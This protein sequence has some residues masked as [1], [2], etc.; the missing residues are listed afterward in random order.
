[1]SANEARPLSRGRA[2]AAALLLSSV[3]S[4]PGPAAANARAPT[5]PVEAALARKE[6]RVG[7]QAFHR[8]DWPVALQHLRKA[9]TLGD[10]N[11]LVALGDGYAFDEFGNTHTEPLA[12]VLYRAAAERANPAGME[13]LG[14]SYLA[15]WYGVHQDYTRARKWLGRAAAA[16]NSEAM[17]DLGNMYCTGNGVTENRHTAH[18]WYSRAAR[19]G[20]SDARAWW[21]EHSRDVLR[22]TAPPAPGMFPGPCMTRQPDVIGTMGSHILPLPK[23]R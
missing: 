4:A 2:C 13:R 16:G 23:Q 12:T 1:M 14:F 5:A 15:G 10:T 21:Q 22:G 19:A 3:L 11:A 8:G 18:L 7:M 17:V 6:Y 9:A 20:N